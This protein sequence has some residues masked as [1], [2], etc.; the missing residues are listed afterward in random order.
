MELNF[1]PEA[2]ALDH[3]DGYLS[4]RKLQP[5]I[6]YPPRPF[7]A[8]EI[9]LTTRCN[10]YCPSCPRVAL[11]GS[12]L[13]Q[14]MSLDNFEQAAEAFDHF[15]TIHFR[16]WGE[17]LLNPH[18]PEMVLRAYQSGAGLVLTTNGQQTLDPGLAQYF[19]T[20]FFRL[21]CGQASVY[22]RRNPGAKFNRTI[23]NIS[24]LLHGRDSIQAGQPRVV[25]LFAKN[26]HTLSQLPA[27][28]E[29]A[30]RLRPD[31]VVFYHPLFHVRRVDD[32]AR[33][34]GDA[35]PGLIAQVDERLATLAA[36]AGLDMINQSPP[37]T[38]GVASICPF[39]PDRSLYLG[40]NGQVG[41]CR[42]SALPLAHGFFTRYLDR[43]SEIQHTALFGNLQRKPLKTIVRSKT[44]REY[45]Q[46]CLIGDWLRIK[47]GHGPAG[48]DQVKARG[49]GKV[50]T[51]AQSVTRSGVC[52]WKRPAG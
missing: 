27:F 22:E 28:L 2:K 25:I 1:L 10:L 31:R 16:G 34:P 38:N 20:V 26:R 37:L 43:R 40:W 12:W 8:L 35:D 7:A 33:L 50:I 45:R 15:E 18:F 6:E 39:D 14:D 11:R 3:Q 13:N 9:E 19:Q 48:N 49:R 5:L 44:F 42:H 21:D 30:V 17:P 47:A 46:A 29:T 24:G 52:S 4:P 23:L 36:S 32:L 51:L 41:I